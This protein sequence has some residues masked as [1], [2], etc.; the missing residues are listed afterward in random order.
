MRNWLQ[1]FA[2]RTS[3]GALIF[4]LAVIIAIL[5]TLAT[6]SYQSWQTARMEPVDSLKYE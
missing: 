3:M 5:V 6:I 2:Y 1:N 4:I